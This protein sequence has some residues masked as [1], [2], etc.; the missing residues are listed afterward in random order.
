MSKEVEKGDKGKDK[1]TLEVKVFA[2]RSPEPKTFEW[3]KTMKVSEAAQEAARAFGYSGGNPGLQ[4]LGEGS[5]VLDP[6]KPL[7]AEH[8]KDGDELELTDRGGGV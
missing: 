3:Q 6:D 7:V 5:H 4:K 2:P 1:S 8:I